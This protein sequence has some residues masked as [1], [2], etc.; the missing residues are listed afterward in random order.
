MIIVFYLA[1]IYTDDDGVLDPSTRQDSAVLNIDCPTRL[2]TSW[3]GKNLTS[4]S[5]TL[6]LF[7][8]SIE[9][10][11]TIHFFNYLSG[12]IK[13]LGNWLAFLFQILCLLACNLSSKL[14]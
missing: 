12:I 11:L 13:M 14:R 7:Q 3:E 6:K 9:I 2:P 4:S 1:Y 5:A 8:F 10:N